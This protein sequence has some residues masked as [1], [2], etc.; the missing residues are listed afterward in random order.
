LTKATIR[1]YDADLERLLLSRSQTLQDV[2]HERREEIKQ[3]ETITLEE[4][5]SG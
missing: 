1:Q 4:A 5:F 3:G 2:L